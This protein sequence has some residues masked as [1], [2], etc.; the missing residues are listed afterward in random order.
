MAAPSAMNFY[1]SFKANI[2]NGNIDLDAGG[3]AVTVTLHTSTYTP[4]AGDSATTNEVGAGNGY[5]TGGVTLTSPTFTQTSGTAKFATG[6]NPS[7]T[8]SGAGFTARTA[9]FRYGSYL[10]GWIVL[11]S[12][13]ADVS[14]AAGNTVTLT[15]HANGWFT[16]T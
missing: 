3:S 9:V 14:F 1:N 15:Q 12:A 13:P 6:T 7:W 11:D 10:I 8:G 4:A 5:S 2:G 16:L